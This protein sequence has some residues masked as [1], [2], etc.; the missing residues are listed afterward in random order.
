MVNL[1]TWNQLVKVDLV[2]PIKQNMLSLAQL[3][4]KNLM[5]ANLVNG[6]QEVVLN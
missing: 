2:L 5:L 3:S 1:R 6:I 4:T